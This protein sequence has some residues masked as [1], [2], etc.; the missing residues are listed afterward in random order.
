[1]IEVKDGIVSLRRAGKGKIFRIPIT[2]FSA[3]DQRYVRQ[4]LRAPNLSLSL[5][6]TVSGPIPN[7]PGTPDNWRP[8]E[9]LVR[10]ED[11]KIEVIDAMTYRLATFGTIKIPGEYMFWHVDRL[12][13]PVF[14]ARVSP[15]AI[16]LTF[17]EPAPDQTRR[18]WTLQRAY[19]DLVQPLHDAGYSKIQSSAVDLHLDLPDTVRFAIMVID[20][21]A[22]EVHILTEIR[23]ASDYT[24]IFQAS[25]NNKRRAARILK[26][27]DTFRSAVKEHSPAAKR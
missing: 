23:F 11:M 5:S 17:V 24:Q 25:S 4:S 8:A 21:E 2:A 15:E 27:A 12:D 26:V 10:K 13:P 9:P 20:A 6:E 7:L 19:N 22:N 1:M 16:N 3:A 18:Q 14:R